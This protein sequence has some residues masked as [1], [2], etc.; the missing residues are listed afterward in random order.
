MAAT[1][2]GARQSSKRKNSGRKRTISDL[3]QYKKIQFSPILL[4]KITQ[5]GGKFKFQNAKSF[6][7]IGIF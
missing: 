3:K 1:S 2:G 6:E 7:G 5:N 4:L